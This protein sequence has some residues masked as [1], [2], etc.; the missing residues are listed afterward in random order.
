MFASASFCEFNYH[1]SLLWYEGALF[2]ID[3]AEF[4]ALYSYTKYGVFVPFPEL[5]T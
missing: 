2:T 5:Y 4:F 3:V 1:C